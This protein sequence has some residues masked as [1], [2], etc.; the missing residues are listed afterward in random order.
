MIG[1]HLS[2]ILADIEKVLW[3]YE[4]LEG[5]KPNYTD[6]AFRA[7]IKIFMSALLDKMYDLQEDEHLSF[8]DKIN[9]AKKA[10]EDLRKLV[11]IYTDIDTVELYK[12]I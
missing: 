8:E 2:P 10:G 6:Q 4:A 9:M 12:E 3:Q 11:K 1:K 7:S 5:K